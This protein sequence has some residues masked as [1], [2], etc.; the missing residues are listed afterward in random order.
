MALF[1]AGGPNDQVDYSQRWNAAT[2][3]VGGFYLV[4]KAFRGHSAVSSQA[5]SWYQ[6]APTNRIQYDGYYWGF[7]SPG[8]S[9]YDEEVPRLNR[10]PEEFAM[11]LH[12]LRETNVPFALIETWNDWNDGTQIE[13]GMDLETGEAYGDVYVDLVRQVMKEENY[14]SPTQPS[15]IFGILL[16]AMVAV[17]IIFP[18]MAPVNKRTM[19][20][21][22][23]SLLSSCS[24][25]G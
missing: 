4:L 11:A 17:L 10:N 25:I 8:Y 24:N 21:Q 1:V 14:A 19:R 18:C 6:F 15:Y 16:L 3:R 9:R 7:V 23:Q 12:R 22:I 13:P 2:S 5:D 20:K